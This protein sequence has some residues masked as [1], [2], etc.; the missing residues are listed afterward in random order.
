ML[1]LFMRRHPGPFMPAWQGYE[2]LAL[3]L[4][5][6][7]K[8]RLKEPALLDWCEFLWREG[9]IE[10]PSTAAYKFANWQATQVDRA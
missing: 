4:Q 10:T 5:V 9:Q 3:A 6:A 2:V 7:E 8:A 1:A